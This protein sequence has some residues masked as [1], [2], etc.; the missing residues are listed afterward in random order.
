MSLLG[1]AAEGLNVYFITVDPKRDTPERMGAYLGSFHPRF[2]GLF[3][4]EDEIRQVADGFGV[5]FSHV[6]DGDDYTVDHSART[7]IVD[8]DGEIPLSFPVSVTPEVMA[9]D[10]QRLLTPDQDASVI[11]EGVDS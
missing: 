10:I 9:R 6:G 3:G 5:Y 8:Q 7:F 2:L 11:R 1:E 4:T